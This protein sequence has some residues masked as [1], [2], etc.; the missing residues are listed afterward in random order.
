[1][2][3]ALN[4]KNIRREG[5]F[6]I[7]IRVAEA[8]STGKIHLA[9]D[10]THCHSPVG[11]RGMNLGIADVAELSRRLIEGTLDGYSEARHQE[12]LTARVITERGRK[13]STG[14]N[15]GRRI[16]F[17]ALVSAARLLPSVRSRLS[18][19]IVEF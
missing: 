2:P 1:M 15:L 10:A 13:R 12:A 6:T 11:S 17:R 9:G 8:S 7:S 16:A 3:L 4:V 18:R 19:L 14:A 5:S